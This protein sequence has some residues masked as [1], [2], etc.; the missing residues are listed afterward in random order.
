MYFSAH[1]CLLMPQSQTEHLQSILGAFQMLAN[2]HTEQHF[3]SILQN[4]AKCSENFVK[5]SQA[6]ERMFSKLW[7]M[8]ST[9]WNMLAYAENFQ[10]VENPQHLPDC[11]GT[12][13]KLPG[14][15]SRMPRGC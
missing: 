13:D 4:V 9:L 11:P 1:A 2:A 14:K 12:A 5:C 15:C 7:N 10:H 8:L 3:H 6:V